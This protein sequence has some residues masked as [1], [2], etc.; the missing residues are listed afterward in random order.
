[1]LMLPFLYDSA[2]N[3]VVNGRD[4]KRTWRWDSIAQARIE[5]QCAAARYESI[6]TNREHAEGTDAR[7]GDGRTQR[8]RTHAKGTGTRTGSPT[9]GK[10][11]G[12]KTGRRTLVL[13][14]EA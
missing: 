12:T 4:G 13:A 10:S 3:A 6:E 14:T 2:H 5:R 9:L 1:M 11:T 7:R 8:G